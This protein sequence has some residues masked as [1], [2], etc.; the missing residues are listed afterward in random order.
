M[1][2]LTIYLSILTFVTSLILG[3]GKKFDE[4]KHKAILMTQSMFE[5]E[6]QT[7][8]TSHQK[9]KEDQKAML[10]AKKTDAAADATFSGLLKQQAEV[11]TQ[12]ENLVKKHDEMAESYKKKEIDGEHA[13]AQEVEMK[14]EDE[15]ILANNKTVE[16]Q[17]TDFKAKVEKPAAPAK[18][19]TTKKKK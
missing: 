13:D 6:H 14:K 7:L 9:H 17:I 8:V 5:A 2:Q 4:E 19:V 15:T 1:K 16:G 18:V 3:C 10:A 12:H 11:L